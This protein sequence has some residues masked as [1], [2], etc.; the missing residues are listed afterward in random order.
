[1]REIHAGGILD[2][3]NNVALLEPENTILLRIELFTLF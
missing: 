2:G 1:M 3:R